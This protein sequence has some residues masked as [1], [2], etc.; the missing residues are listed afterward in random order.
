MKF[1]PGGNDWLRGRALAAR[2]WNLG[3]PPADLEQIGLDLLLADLV[4]A[5][6]FGGMNESC[7]R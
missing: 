7:G 3:K 6:I 4:P 5:T 2:P 1:H